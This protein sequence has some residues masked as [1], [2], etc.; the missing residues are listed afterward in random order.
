MADVFE[1][2]NNQLWIEGRKKGKIG[3]SDMN[4]SSFTK[5]LF[6]QSY[7]YGSCQFSIEWYKRLN[8][9]I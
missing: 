4:V 5:E 2:E 7:N 6:Y 8:G 9:K 1:Y 3:L